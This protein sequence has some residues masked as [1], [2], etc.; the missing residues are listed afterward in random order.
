MSL[1][2]LACF[3]VPQALI[4]WSTK[5]QWPCCI[6]SL[7]S[8]AWCEICPFSFH[9]P[10]GWKQWTSVC[11]RITQNQWQSNWS[12]QAINLAQSISNCRM[13][14]WASTSTIHCFFLW[15]Y[16]NCDCFVSSTTFY[17]RKSRNIILQKQYAGVNCT[18]LNLLMVNLAI[19]I[20]HIRW[21]L[22]TL[23]RHIFMWHFVFFSADTLDARST[24]DIREQ[25]RPLA[26][27]RVYEQVIQR[28]NR[29]QHQVSNS[30]DSAPL[31]E[32]ETRGLTFW[33]GVVASWR[34]GGLGDRRQR[35]GELI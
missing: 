15:L 22:A 8:L 11:L 3:L 9:W 33:F 23:R 35:Y 2:T 14:L 27:E 32:S 16:L 26:G 13:S 10:Y 1:T 18:C 34:A 24:P 28:T 25:F 29:A 17:R 19:K 20:L 21:N 5:S 4:S 30:N 12:F 31:D 7:C 6:A